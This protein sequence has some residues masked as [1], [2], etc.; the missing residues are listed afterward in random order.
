MRREETESS[1]IE[2]TRL[3][4]VRCHDY[5][6]GTVLGEQWARPICDPS[7]SPVDFGQ[8]WRFTFLWH[9]DKRRGHLLGKQLLQSGVGHTL[10]QAVGSD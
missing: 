4:S 2:L 1:T 8:L 5:P 7:G 6:R 9:H 3:S 10:G